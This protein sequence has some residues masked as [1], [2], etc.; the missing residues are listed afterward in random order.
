METLSQIWIWI[1]S[2]LGGIS[3]SAVFAF[4]IKISLSAAFNKIISKINVQKIADQATEK[5]IEKVK[6]ISFTHNIQPLVESEL[7]KINEKST[8]ILKQT[9]LEVQAK[10]DKVINVLDKLSKYFDNSIGVAEE[11]KEELREALSEALEKPIIVESSIVEEITEP[12]ETNVKAEK[13]T[14]IKVER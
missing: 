3:L 12:K 9:L 14:T 11:K 5:G 8:E 4:I 7:K 2:I 1:V 6:K 13:T 10:Y